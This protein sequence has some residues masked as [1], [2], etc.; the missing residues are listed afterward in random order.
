M[1]P[2]LL[3]LL[4]ILYAEC[5]VDAKTKITSRFLLYAYFLALVFMSILPPAGFSIL[6]ALVSYL[7]CYGYLIY[8]ND[9]IL[10]KVILFLLSVLQCLNYISIYSESYQTFLVIPFYFEYSNMILREL[11]VLCIGLCT[12]DFKTDFNIKVL[13]VILY[14]IE[15]SY[16]AGI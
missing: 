8:V 3:P 7:L 12:V 10:V 14:L 16:I 4:L 1:S 15:Y 6:M 5:S 2:F 11:T 9:K 13:T